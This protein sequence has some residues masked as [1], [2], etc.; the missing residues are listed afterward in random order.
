M[1]MVLVRVYSFDC[2]T[3]GCTRISEDYTPPGDVR[4]PARWARQQA[5]HDGWKFTR[6]GMALCPDCARPGR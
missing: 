1:G 2:D 4:E 6:D 3:P 5:R